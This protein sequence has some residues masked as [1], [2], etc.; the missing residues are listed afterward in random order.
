MSKA[1]KALTPAIPKVSGTFH[2]VAKVSHLLYEAVEVELKDGVV[3]SVKSVSRA[4]DLAATAVGHCSRRIW[5]E[6]R[7]QEMG[8]VC[9]K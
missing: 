4:P 3:V 9:P 6:L 7:G 2:T 1:T 8:E 5:E